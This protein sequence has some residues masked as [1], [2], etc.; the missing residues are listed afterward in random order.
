MP[1][2]G[3]PMPNLVPDRISGIQIVS[4]QL[5]RVGG[6]GFYVPMA[7]VLFLFRWCRTEFWHPNCLLLCLPTTSLERGRDWFSS[8]CIIPYDYSNLQIWGSTFFKSAP[9]TLPRGWGRVVKSRRDGSGKTFLRS[10]CWLAEG[11]S[12]WFVDWKQ[13][14]GDFVFGWAAKKNHSSWFLNSQTIGKSVT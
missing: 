14:I 12:G 3:I 4:H 11:L 13:T 6:G 10:F 8:C 7:R 5:L 1:N 2:V 9:S